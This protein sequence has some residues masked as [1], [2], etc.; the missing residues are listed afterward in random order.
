MDEL[1]RV[2]IDST[3]Y[4]SIV[5]LRLELDLVFRAHLNFS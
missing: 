2:L 5:E 4:C 3:L 1:N